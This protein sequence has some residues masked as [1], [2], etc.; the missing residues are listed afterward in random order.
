[1]W[2][3]AVPFQSHIASKSTR[4]TQK[5]RPNIALF[6][7]FPI[8]ITGEWVKCLSQFFV[9]HLWPNHWYTFD[10]WCWTISTI[11]LDCKKSSAAK[12]I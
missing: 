9:R 6:D 12:H 8:K 7:L 1:M 10:G 11:S 3:Y 4:V 5:M 2:Q